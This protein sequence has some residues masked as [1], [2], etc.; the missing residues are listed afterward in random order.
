MVANRKVTGTAKSMP[1][2]LALGW[3]IS[4]GF[5]ILGA[6]VFASLIS[7]E[8]L[9]E[10]M[11]GYCAMVILLVASMLGAAVSV[12]AIKRRRAY[13]C[14]LSGMIYY[15]TLLSMTA[16]FFGGQYQGMGVTALLVLAGVGMVLLLGLRGERRN[17]AR[18]HKNGYR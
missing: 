1:G 11:I 12:G 18:H 13:V 3:A 7:K 5:T 15:A 2:G 6:M 8:L 10:D 14:G 4:F 16:L 17:N 9:R